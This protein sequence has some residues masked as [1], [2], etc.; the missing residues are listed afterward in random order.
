MKILSK[1]L[2]RGSVKVVPE[3]TD[4]IWVLHTVI[5]PGDLV[6]ART[7]REVHFGERGSG[8]SSRVPM[9]LTI[10][11]EKTEFQA[12]TT[13]LRVRGVVVEGPEKYGVLGKYH[14]MSIDVGRELEIVKPKGWPRSLLEKLESRGPQPA[15]VIVAVDYDEYA[16]AVARG[17]G[18]RVV[19]EGSLHLPGKDDPSREDALRESVAVIAKTVA[20]V[21]ERE[22]PLLVVVAG[23]GSLKD[24]VAERLHPLLPSRVKLYTD[25]VSMGGHAGVLEEVR[26]GVMRSA[27]REAAA[28]Q[29]ERLMEEFERLLAKEPCRVAYTL[30][31][32]LEAASMG[33]VE[34]L[35]VLDEMLHHPDPE[36]RRRVDELLRLAD[37]TRAEIHF[38][39]AEAPAGARVKSLGG[40][41]AIL[42]YALQLG[43]KACA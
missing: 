20:G 41:V 10:R 22:N 34:K 12:F 11:V 35:L 18:V 13:R 29:A 16:V 6:R 28:I 43:G 39:S 37:S 25:N 24:I 42:R 40:V 27:L 38:V 31:Q 5:Q 15:A 4:D 9:T 8:R 21:V 7:V 2:K 36:V 26:R 30:D 33:A 1:N 17:Q 23:P 3:T 32:V 14:T 19:A